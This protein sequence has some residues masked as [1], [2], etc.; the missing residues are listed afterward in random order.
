MLVRSIQ[1]YRYQDAI[2][3]EDI[4]GMLGKKKKI[5]SY[6]TSNKSSKD[7]DIKIDCTISEVKQDQD[8]VNGHFFY[9]YQEKINRNTSREKYSIWG[10]DYHFSILPKAGILIVYGTGKFRSQVR[11]LL[12]RT[13]HNETRGFFREII[14]FKESMM[15]LVKEISKDNKKNDVEKPSFEYLEHKYNDW[16]ELNFATGEE[17][18]VTNHRDFLKFYNP[19]TLWSPKMRIKECTGI[20]EDPVE[21]RASLLM[22]YNTSFTFS[23]HASPNQWK[24][25]VLTKCKKALETS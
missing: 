8:G 14:I 15:G 22:K 12:S 21:D 2:T 25:F 20:L 16:T 17:L 24:K 13:I 5:V 4:L 19:A 10:E 1:V 3:K 23:K 6:K 7:R 18:C 11:N 9:Q